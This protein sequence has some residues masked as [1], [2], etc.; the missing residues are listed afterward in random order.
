M[1][2]LYRW[3]AKACSSVC[4]AA[5]VAGPV[6][7]TAQQSRA[8]Q[9]VGPNGPGLAC[10]GCS[11]VCG[12]IGGGGPGGTPCAGRCTGGG[13]FCWSDCACVQVFD[14]QECG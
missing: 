2:T 7:A 5:L 8:A 4:V 10:D 6:V 9:R 1:T 14:C 11:V 12:P 3:M 13:L